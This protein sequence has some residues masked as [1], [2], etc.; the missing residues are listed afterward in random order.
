[1][2]LR[3]AILNAIDI[4][5]WNQAFEMYKAAGWTLK[6]N[7]MEYIP[8]PLDLINDAKK[9]ARNFPVSSEFLDCIDSI[10]Y[11]SGSGIKIQADSGL[12]GIIT[13]SI[14]KSTVFSCYNLKDF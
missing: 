10:S 14:I 4:F 6:H 7:G 11:Q 9:L 3:K 5:D 12:S 1:M 13:I 2:N 8:T